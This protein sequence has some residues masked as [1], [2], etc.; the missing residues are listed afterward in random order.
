[1][2]T[3]QHEKLLRH[4]DKHSIARSH[5]LAAIGVSATT[6]ARAI[7][8]NQVIRVS[9]GLYQLTNADIDANTA[10]IEVSKLVPNAVICLTSVLGFHGLTDQLP[11]NT[12]IAIGAKDWRPTMTYPA[13]QVVRFREPYFSG[14]IET[15]QIGGV[16]VRMYTITKT[17]ADAFR[18]PKRVDRSVAIESLRN[19][20]EA[21]K[22]SP[23]ALAASAKTYG[24]WNMMK[25]Y[26][27]ALTSHG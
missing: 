26:L 4:L 16:N 8:A 19:V 7:K 21:R 23:A 9:R 10:L 13:I 25:P 24:A 27:E 17:I 15:H 12:W 6:V 11:R 18:N 20:L 1:M 2:I 14:D 3:T 5:E 22:A